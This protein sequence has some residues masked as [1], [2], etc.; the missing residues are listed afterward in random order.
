MKFFNRKKPNIIDVANNILDEKQRLLCDLCKDAGVKC[1][2]KIYCL[3]S[4]IL[5][6]LLYDDKL[7]VHELLENLK[8]N[9]DNANKEAI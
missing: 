9:L 2:S 1:K 6:D 8:E 4:E 7:S 5:F 3:P